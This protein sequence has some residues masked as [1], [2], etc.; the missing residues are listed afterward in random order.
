MAEEQTS[1]TVVKPVPEAPVDPDIDSLLQNIP[2]LKAVFAEK[3][4][5]SEQKL[6]EGAPAP[7]PGAPETAP[8]VKFEV[9]E[10][11]K[12]EDE[13]K[14]PPEEPKKE[15]PDKVQRRID[16]LTA[17]RKVAEERVSVLETE[18]ADLKS[19]FQAPPPIAPTPANPLADIDT[20]EQLESKKKLIL[21][22]KNWCIR[23]PNGGQVSDGKGGTKFVDDAA[24]REIWAN[25]DQMLDVELPKR[26][27]F[28]AA[29]KLFVNEARREYP[30]L[31]KQ[32]SEAFTTKVTWLKALPECAN[33]PDIDLII[34]D[35]IVGQ[36]FRLD[37]AKARAGGN[38]KVPPASQTPLAAPAPAASPR[39]PQNKALS[40]EALAAAFATDPNA[41]L[42]NFVGGLIDAAAAQRAR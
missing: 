20:D 33:F 2:D 27:E 19:K 30:A 9:P 11:L 39:V 6:K 34:G 29:R 13:E 28:L 25:A 4:G 42:D 26:K 16:E 40:G 15:E 17:K 8:E 32:G 41:A 21:E 22:A 38:G 23:N 31:Y 10:G 3:P 7:E 36:K 14:P 37:R 35:A 24:V 12:P 5:D 1:Q 18:L